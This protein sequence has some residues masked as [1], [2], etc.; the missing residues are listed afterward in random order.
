[1]IL[2]D[3]G[4]FLG[5]K[6]VGAVITVAV[7]AAGVWCWQHPDAV[8]AFGHVVKMTLIWLAV[9]AALPWSSYLYMRPLL[10]VQ[11]D[12]LS[13]GAAK[14]LSIAVIAGYCLADV[15][16]GLWLADWTISG[17]LS[18]FVVLTGFAAAAVYNFVICE[19]LAR[20]VEA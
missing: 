9:V 13:A 15:L 2:G 12:R 14:G 7:I 20:N 11:S 1:M 4:K 19:S 16:L 10:R 6:A 18:W 3:I 5:Q 17:A 8:R